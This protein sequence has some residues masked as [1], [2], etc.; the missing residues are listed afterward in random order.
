MSGD[1]D[2]LGI[3]SELIIDY[4]ILSS[5]IIL[6]P[7]KWT[8]R[9]SQTLLRLSGTRNL[10]TDLLPVKN[11]DIVHLFFVI[12]SQLRYDKARRRGIL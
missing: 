1:S 5:L 12:K 7:T 10:E 8:F 4:I 2:V 9:I 11:E 3:F 6:I